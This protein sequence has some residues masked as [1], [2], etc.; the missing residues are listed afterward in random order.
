MNGIFKRPNK[1]CS[2]VPILV[3]FQTIEIATSTKKRK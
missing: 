3:V 2:V 1:C